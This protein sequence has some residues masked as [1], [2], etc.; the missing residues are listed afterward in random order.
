MQTNQG[1][2]LIVWVIV[3]LSDLHHLAEGESG[4]IYQDTATG[5]DNG[6][7]VSHMAP[8][9]MGDMMMVGNRWP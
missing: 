9:D 5:V 8:G 4:R 1:A 7:V 3:G 2:Q 6:Q